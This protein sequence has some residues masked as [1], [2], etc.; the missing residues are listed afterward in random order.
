MNNCNQ[1]GYG[2]HTSGQFE[3]ILKTELAKQY[4]IVM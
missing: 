4:E 3:N 2:C 1:S